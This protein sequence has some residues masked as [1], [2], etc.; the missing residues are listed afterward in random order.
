MPRR[1]GQL[2]N[3]VLRGEDA[4]EVLHALAERE[5]TASRII[6]NLGQRILDLE[7]VNL[8]NGMDREADGLDMASY[9]VVFTHPQRDTNFVAFLSDRQTWK[10]GEY[11]RSDFGIRF[12]VRDTIRGQIQDPLHLLQGPT[13]ESTGDWYNIR[14]V[15]ES[16]L[17]PIFD[18]IRQVYDLWN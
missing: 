15:E 16:Y 10:P 4:S 14:R 1:R 8:R 12:R 6:L 11:E 9:A 7:G 17:E 3:P 2:N 13:R 5:T 18:L